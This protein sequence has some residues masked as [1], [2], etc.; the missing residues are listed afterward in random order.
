MFVCW[1]GHRFAQRPG[2]YRI[3]NNVPIEKLDELSGEDGYD[4]IM[5]FGTVE[6]L[7]GIKENSGAIGGLRALMRVV[8]KSYRQGT[9]N[10]G[11]KEHDGES[12]WIACVKSV[13]GKTGLGKN[14]IEQNDAQDRG[15][16]GINLMIGDYGSYKHAKNI[17]HDDAWIR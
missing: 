13:Q 5:A 11:C 7:V 1:E 3:N 6:Q 8:F 10:L 16:D 12:D 4:F 9:C 17:D 14:E 2:F 15:N